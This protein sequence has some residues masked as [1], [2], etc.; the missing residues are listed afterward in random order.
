MARVLRIPRS[1]EQDSFILIHVVSSGSGPLNLT[2]TATEGECPYAATIKASQLKGLR[3]KNYQG[4]DDEWTQ[5]ISYILK[6]S[7]SSTSS[8]AYTGVE[9]SAS[10]TG[11]DDEN[12]ELV[13]TIRKRVQSITQKLG[14]I[15]LKQ[16]DDQAIELFE[17]S[18]ISLARVEELE[19]QTIELSDRCRV[20]DE[21]IQK[22]KE[23]LDEL[24]KAKVQHESKL[25]ANFA[26]LLNEKKLKIRNQQ[27]LLSAAT[28][29]PS[30]VAEIRAHSVQSHTAKG[31]E[32]LAKR[33]A[34]SLDDT[35][36]ESD[37]GF[38][39]MDVDKPR[40][41][42]SLEDQDTEDEDEDGSRTTDDD[43]DGSMQDEVPSS[44]SQEQ[45]N[46][47]PQRSNTKEATPPPRRELPFTR[48]KPAEQPE[49]APIQSEVHVGGETAG[50]TDDD[51]L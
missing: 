35:D 5:I 27:R 30:K 6:Q 33:G 17:W 19:N 47:D 46:D 44:K 31:E 15:T 51:E 45:D 1:D 29:D 42:N 22:L 8:A 49:A 9:T 37:D 38:E 34:Q 39:K 41:G 11:S 36:D 23:Q 13:I 21:T 14:S 20:A 3:A 48:R 40:S 18:G 26:Q 12:K 32:N 4:S 10:I 43:S 24:I 16:D 7:T 28:V 2:L 50:E 25:I